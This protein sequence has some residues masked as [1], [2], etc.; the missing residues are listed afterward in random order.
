MQ[1]KKCRGPS[2]N[3]TRFTGTL[4]QESRQEILV[5]E[6]TKEGVECNDSGG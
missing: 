2:Y 5:S 3:A 1:G 4:E 6:Y